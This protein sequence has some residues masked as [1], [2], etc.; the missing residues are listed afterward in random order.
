MKTNR[1]NTVLWLSLITLVFLIH[2]YCFFYGHFGYDDMHYARLSVNLLSGTWDV[3]DH[4]SHRLSIIG[5][6]ALSYFI[7]GISDFASGFF[8]LCMSIG[9]CMMICHVLYKHGLLMQVIGLSLYFGYQWNLFYSDKL[10][11][12]I[13]VSF[14]ITTTYY[15]RWLVVSGVLKNRTGGVLFAVALFC[16]FLSKGTFILLL[17]LFLFLLIVDIN[18][19]SLRHF[20]TYAIVTT[21]ILGIA[22]LGWNHVMFDNPLIRLEMIERGSYINECSY[23]HYGV[24]RIVQRLTTDFGNFVVNERLYIYLIIMVV[25]VIYGWISSQP[26]KYSS[27]DL[28]TLVIV[29]L[30]M[31]FMTISFGEYNPFCLDPRHFMMATPILAVATARMVS[32][33][34]KPFQIGILSMTV[35]FLYPTVQ[36]IIDSRKLNYPQVKES[37]LMTL[38]VLENKEKST[39]YASQVLINLMDYYSG[40]DLSS[41]VELVNI[42]QIQSIECGDIVIRNWYGEFHSHLDSDK[43]DEIIA[44]YTDITEHEG[45]RLRLYVQSCE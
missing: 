17:P 22:Y 23:A 10:M 21:G 32:S 36:Y 29:L 33:L 3:M 13:Y 18:N 30:S 34:A 26:R 38:D 24:E 15:S 2:H 37:I 4:Y 43:Y 7:F 20:W 11:A 16:S 27:K 45:N 40:F 1:T 5:S 35:L 31:N 25:V 6:T 19:R 42:T 14:F 39:V 8:P 41:R 28:A 9:I 12:D 44:G